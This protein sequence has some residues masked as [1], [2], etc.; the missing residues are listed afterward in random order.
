M[1]LHTRLQTVY[2]PALLETQ[3]K[4]LEPFC[5][6]A[7][8]RFS[9]MPHRPKPPTQSLLPVWWEEWRVEGLED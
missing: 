3:V 9:G 6:R 4:S 8:I 2:V 7:A 5:T 1:G